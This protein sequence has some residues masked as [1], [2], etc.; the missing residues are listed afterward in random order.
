MADGHKSIQS[1]RDDQPRTERLA[2]YARDYGMALKRYFSRRGAP[3]ELADDLTQE[4]FVRLAGRAATTKIE[5]AEAY[6]MQTASSVWKDCLRHR[7]R[8]SHHDHIHYEE[9]LHAPEAFSPE[10]VFE[11][12]EAV[13][14]LAEA[15]YALPARTRQIYVHC[16]I[17]GMKRKEVAKRFGISVSAIEKHLMKATEHIG[18]LFG[19]EE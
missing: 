3:A 11:G 14:R 10:R 7:Q 1:P 2:G 16:R 6:L 15:L 4:V 18:E 17:D 5:N 9:E 13:Q 8:R 19:D 12:R